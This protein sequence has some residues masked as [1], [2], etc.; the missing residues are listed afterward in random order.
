[1]FLLSILIVRGCATRLSE[2]VRFSATKTD[3]ATGTL[4]VNH[5]ANNSP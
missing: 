3:M 1:M 5:S 2:D 4:T